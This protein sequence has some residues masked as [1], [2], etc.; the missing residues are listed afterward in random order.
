MISD[1]HKNFNVKLLGIASSALTGC[2]PAPSGRVIQP[3]EYGADPSGKTDSSAALNASV[4]ALI[5]I[6]G[7][8]DDQGEV[9]V[10]WYE[11]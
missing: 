3:Q 10:R 1:I 9:L 4:H 7:P 11:G 8:K 2:V 5:G 6:G